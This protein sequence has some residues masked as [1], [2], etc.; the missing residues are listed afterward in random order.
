MFTN[1]TEPWAFHVESYRLLGEK[2]PRIVLRHC[3]RC[4]WCG[5]GAATA[6]GQCLKGACAACG[7]CP[8]CYYPLSKTEIRETAGR[9]LK[10]ATAYRKRHRLPNDEQVIVDLPSSG[11]RVHYSKSERDAIREWLTPAAV[12]VAGWVC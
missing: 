10:I 1:E 3:A 4:E 7:P 6:C 12:F 9:I 5:D 11:F 2:L 8:E